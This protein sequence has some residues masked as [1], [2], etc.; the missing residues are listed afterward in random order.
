M[1]RNETQ[2]VRISRKVARSLDRHLQRA[3]AGQSRQFLKS[4][5]IEDAILDCIR[6]RE[7][8]GNNQFGQ[9]KA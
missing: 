6:L 7:E 8:M 4:R 5:F 1:K 2:S 9:I 3:N